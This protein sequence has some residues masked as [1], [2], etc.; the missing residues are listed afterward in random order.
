M[1]ENWIYCSLCGECC[2]RIGL[3]DEKPEYSYCKEGFGCNT[4]EEGIMKMNNLF[5]KEKQ[6]VY[7]FTIRDITKIKKE[8]AKMVGVSIKVN[9]RNYAIK[10]ED[11]LNF[12][13][14]NFMN[15]IKVKISSEAL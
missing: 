1:T 2:G 6:N 3:D 8:G 9:K 14:M 4:G 7:L 11:F 10:K 13:L 15:D 12:V 5:E